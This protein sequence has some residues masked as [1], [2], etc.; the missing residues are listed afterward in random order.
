MPLLRQS[1]QAVLASSKLNCH[2]KHGLSVIDK[3]HSLLVKDSRFALLRNSITSAVTRCM[4]L[5]GSW[6]LTLNKSDKR[7]SHALTKLTHRS[8]QSVDH[9][10][11]PASLLKRRPSLLGFV[12]RISFT[13][14]LLAGT[15]KKNT[16]SQQ[17][18]RFVTMLPQSVTSLTLRSASWNT[19][20]ALAARRALTLTTGSTRSRSL[21]SRKPDLPVP[22]SPA[23]TWSVAGRAFALEG[24]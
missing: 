4:T 10:Y 1:H 18:T 8:E 6:G 14:S 17:L 5:H 7:G 15:K 3:L 16:T 13:V 12:N 2:E 24:S 11:D 20:K 23:L 22:S 19:T 9:Y 21:P